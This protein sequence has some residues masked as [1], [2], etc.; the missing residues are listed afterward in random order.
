MITTEQLRSAI[1]KR[2]DSYNQI[3]S[4]LQKSDANLRAIRQP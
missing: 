2:V 3:D 4:P 1:T